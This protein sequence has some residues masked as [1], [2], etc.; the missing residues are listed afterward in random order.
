MKTKRTQAIIQLLLF[1]GIA[2]FLNVLGNIFFTTF[3]LTEEKR[4]TLT[5]PTQQLL[6]DLDEVVYVQVLLDGELPAGVKRLQTATQ[7]MLDDFRSHSGYIEYEITNPL[8]GNVEENNAAKQELAKENILPTSLRVKGTEDTRQL[9]FYTY[10]IVH[11]KGRTIP[12]N[13]VEKEGGVLD[14]YT[15]NN[16]VSLLE[17][18]IAN[19]IQK[20]QT[21]GKPYIAFTTGHGE[22]Q[23]VQTLD[24]RRSLYSFYNVGFI[25][26]DSAYVIPQDIKVL[27]IAKPQMEFSERDK[28]LID[29]YIMNG[30]KVMWL[31]DRMAVNL[32]SMY[33]VKNYIPHDY[34]L[35]LDDQLFKY[36]ARIQPNLV[37]DMRC[38]QIELLISAN[39]KARDKF[40]W[41]Y[42]P[43]AVPESQHPIVKNLD[44]VNLF[45]P[46]K[47]DTIKTKTNIK[48]TVL[49]ESSEYSR[50]QFL[51]M[52]LNFEILR[53]EPDPT[54]FNKGK[55]PLAV[56]YEGEFPSL[57]ENRV[58]DNMK[59]MLDK[60]EQPFKDRS[61]DTKMLVVGDGDVIKNL[62]NPTDNTPIPLGFNRFM[63][64]TFA[65]KAFLVNAIEYMLD[66]RGVI[67][68]RAKDVKLRLLDTVKAKEERRKWQLVNLLL[69]ILFLFLFG[70][71][72]NFTRKKRYAK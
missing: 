44:G 1:I 47:V 63:R 19:A 54:K 17:Y 58:T 60:I 70:A 40:N 15:I 43:I 42:H 10:A 31:I 9:L 56:M 6:N 30:G 39:D 32:D 53:Y 72:F 12:V 45:F 5:K 52:R 22:L 67:E 59:E 35:N 7:E 26:M 20:L 37:L 28:F 8:V 16:S 21:Y 29:Q 62:I 25:N 65:N 57:Y 69:P 38:S 41:Y 68:A 11:Y 23:E 27:I 46:S 18:K 3:D 24:I 48:K 55:Q 61:V 49:L 13:L 33:R 14:E 2:I 36:G 66:E 71:I 4:F 34:P 64:Y 51:P 50:E